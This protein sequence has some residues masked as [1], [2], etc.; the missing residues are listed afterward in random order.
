[1]LSGGVAVSL[2]SCAGKVVLEHHL[3]WTFA[4]ASTGSMDEDVAANR[5]GIEGAHRD[6]HRVGLFANQS[7][8]RWA[9]C[10]GGYLSVPPPRARG[11]LT[12]VVRRGDH[13]AGTA[14]H[15]HLYRDEARSTALY[16]IGSWPTMT[17]RR[18]ARLHRPLG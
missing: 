9:A 18:I 15:N 3:I 7:V 4:V 10:G 6:I 11:Y 12:V 17:T 5:V 2:V 8:R 14:R 13:V 16:T 1:M